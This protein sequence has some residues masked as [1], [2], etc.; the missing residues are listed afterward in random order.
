MKRTFAG[1]VVVFMFIFYVN[2][3]HALLGIDDDVVGYDVLVPFFLVSMPDQGNMNT[4]ITIT[5]TCESAASF[6]YKVYNTSGYLKHNSSLSLTKCDVA[7][8][9]ALTIVNNMSAASRISFEVDLD[10]DG[11]NDHYAGYIVFENK[12]ITAL[13]N[14]VTASA[15]LV[16]LKKA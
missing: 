9:D 8:I 4:L 7:W 3:S 2:P 11:T 15:Y 1:F 16:D 5:E 13:K 12:D 10:R 14:Q 6:H